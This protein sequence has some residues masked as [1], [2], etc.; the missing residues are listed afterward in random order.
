MWPCVLAI[1]LG[2]ERGQIA[3]ASG[4]RLRHGGWP[5]QL[6]LVEE[7]RI[8]VEP[9]GHRAQLPHLPQLEAPFLED[10]LDDVGCVRQ[11]VAKGCAA[12]FLSE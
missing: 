3:R 7:S 4:E 12:R 11:S 6:V 5:T 9:R 1:L 10:P 8:V 2:Q